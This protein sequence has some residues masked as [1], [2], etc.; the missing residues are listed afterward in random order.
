[1][2]TAKPLQA[3]AMDQ[4]EMRRQQE[5]PSTAEILAPALASIPKFRED[6]TPPLHDWQRSAERGADFA[7]RGEL[8]RRGFEQQKEMQDRELANQHDTMRL[9]AELQAKYR[10]RG[11]GG[12]GP[13]SK[14]TQEYLK[15]WQADPPK[16]EQQA[17]GRRQRMEMIRTQLSRLGSS[18]RRASDDLSMAQLTPDKYSIEATKRTYERESDTAKAAA[19]SEEMRTR[20]EQEA[21]NVETQARQRLIPK[22]E[23]FES[24]E[25]AKERAKREKD[26]EESIKRMRQSGGTPI[27][28]GGKSYM[29]LH[30][31]N[32]V[33]LEA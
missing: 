16:D 20:A 12:P 5:R 22:K 10:P 19:R 32:F 14:L 9:R 27:S 7:Q 18:G 26:L 2:A 6:R 24:P 23:M 33:E 17:Y 31:G 8:Q 11:R 13:V 21:A 28:Y 3:W 29:K 15:L 25:A 4:A 1:M 30:D